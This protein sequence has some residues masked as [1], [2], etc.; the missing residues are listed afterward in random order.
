MKISLIT[1]GKTDDA[2]LA[3]EIDKYIKRIAHY[4]PFE[5]VYL[6]D[7]K[8]IKNSTKKIQKQKEFEL[9]DKKLKNFETV[10][11]L[12]EGGKEYSSKNFSVLIQTFLNRGV[13]TIAFVIGGP[14]GFS[15][16]MYQKYTNKISLS[17]MTFSHQMI[18]LL[19]VEQVYRANTI[20]KGESY[21][22]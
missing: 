12:D 17:K 21:H 16:E 5:I 14:Y 20:I 13:R 8:R 15:D 22:H 11:L 19:F 9:L 7:V 3:K 2:F 10:F 1:I 18:R 4:I 6:S